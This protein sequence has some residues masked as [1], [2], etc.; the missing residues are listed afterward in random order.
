MADLNDFHE[1]CRNPEVGPNAGWKPHESLEESQKILESWIGVEEIWALELKE[2]GKAVGSVGLHG[3]KKREDVPGCKMLGYVLSTDYWGKGLM[4]EAVRAVIDHVFRDQKLS[5]LSVCHYPFN[6]R[7]RRVIEKS[8]FHFEGLQRRGSVIY[9]GTVVDDCLYSMTRREYLAM[10]AGEAYELRL[11]E[12]VGKAEYLDYMAEW[13]GECCTPSAVDK[14]DGSYESWLEQNIRFRTKVPE[15][16]VT[17]TSYFLTDKTGKPLGAVDI[18]HSLNGHLMK[19][20]GHIG[21]GVRKSCRKMGCASAMLALALEKCRELGIERALVTCDEDNPGSAKT[22]ES[23]GGVL[24]NR[25]ED[26]GKL[27]RR[28]WIE[29]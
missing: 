28:Y 29:V 8:G 21:Y 13:E 1:Y 16:L 19:T 14:K 3:D 11:P 17:A 7:S 26:G 22:I 9:D 15:G 23:C 24:E 5:L 27:V 20:G 12:E 2:N 10:R 18:R 25:V 6:R 4:T